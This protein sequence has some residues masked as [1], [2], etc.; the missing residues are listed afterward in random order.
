MLVAA[1]AQSG[2]ARWKEGDG[3]DVSLLGRSAVENAAITFVR[4][5]RDRDVAT[6]WMFS[7]EEEQDAFGTESEA[8]A[9]SAEDFPTLQQARPVKFLRSWQE[10]DTPFVELTLVDNSGSEYR[11]AMGFWLDDAGDW[12]LVSCDVKAVSDRVAAR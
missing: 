4:A 8:Y 7:S 11:A 10:G 9:A 3:G 1:P 5:M 12:K 2:N 6:V